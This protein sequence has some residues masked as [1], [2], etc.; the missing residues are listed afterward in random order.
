MDEKEMK[1]FLDKTGLPVAYFPYSVKAVIMHSN[2]RRY[3]IGKIYALCG[4]HHSSCLPHSERT[5]FPESNSRRTA[6]YCRSVCD[7]VGMIWWNEFMN[8]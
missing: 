4:V 1:A 2:Q 8:D 5:A 6:D 3:D 7:D